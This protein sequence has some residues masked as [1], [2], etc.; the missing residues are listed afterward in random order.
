MKFSLKLLIAGSIDYAGMFPPARLPLDQAWS[1]FDAYRREPDGWLLGLFVC[2]A[3]RLKELAGLVAEARQRTAS[4]ATD[5][6]KVRV[7][8]LG[9]GGASRDEFVARL[10][11][12]LH[13]IRD[14]TAS[15]EPA[16]H[17]D[18]LELRLP[19]DVLAADSAG[20]NDLLATVADRVQVAG[21]PLHAVFYEAPLWDNW[22]DAVARVV[23]A[24]ARKGDGGS[25]APAANATGSQGTGS[26]GSDSRGQT[27]CRAGFKLRTGGLEASA[28]PT[29]EQVAWTIAACRDA[30][31]PWKATAGLHQPLAHFDAALG[32]RHYGFVN[33]FAATALA[34]A[35]RLTEAEII[36]ILTE[37]S[38]AAFEFADDHLSCDD[39]R[40][41][42]DEIAR[43]RQG[44][45]MSF[46]SCSF[47]EPRE[48][49]HAL[50]WL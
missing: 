35:H 38:A 48:G 25:S 7:T 4:D 22:R 15:S 13:A 45:L 12:D 47:D 24:I 16:I 14:V 18:T 26:R 11:D 39:R 43:V 44:G 9:A 23:E 49:L 50:G 46:G 10:I 2:P 27:T 20:L 29:A 40:A 31:V 1:A 8:A 6:Y 32:V 34:H 5:C 36:P 30:G 28:F 21:V 41:S 19:P 42:V 33:L 17:V 37:Q 3:Q